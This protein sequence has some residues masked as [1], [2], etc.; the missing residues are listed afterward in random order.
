MSN[1]HPNEKWQEEDVK[2]ALDLARYRVSGSCF[3][4]KK[5]TCP[6]CGTYNWIDMTVGVESCKCFKCNKV[7]WIS[8]KIYDD[9]KLSLV[10]ARVFDFEAKEPEDTFY[11][12]ESPD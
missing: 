2:I 6:D 1:H 7:F 9:Y 8:E 12:M 5:S 11:G 10:M 3:S 4:W